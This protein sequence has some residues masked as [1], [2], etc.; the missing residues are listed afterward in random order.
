M[1]KK[2]TDERER[3]GQE[4]RRMGG[5]ER[6]DKVAKEDGNGSKLGRKKRNVSKN[7]NKRR[8]REAKSKKN[9]I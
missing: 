8:R 6:D 5:K 4:K 3:E 2:N 9:G 7:V 1:T